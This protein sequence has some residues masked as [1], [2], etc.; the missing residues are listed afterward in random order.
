ML[1]LP[2]TPMSVLTKATHFP[3]S[4]LKSNRN[5]DMVDRW[6]NYVQLVRRNLQLKFSCSIRRNPSLH[7]NC[8]ST[9]LAVTV[10]TGKLRSCMYRGFFSRQLPP[11]S[12][13]CIFFARLKPPPTASSSFHVDYAPWFLRTRVKNSHQHS[14]RPRIPIFWYRHNSSGTQ[15]LNTHS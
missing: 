10:R 1:T 8:A 11:T 7:E 9:N 4:K 12:S 15:R 14:N 5:V 3:G 2:A 13:T 6:C